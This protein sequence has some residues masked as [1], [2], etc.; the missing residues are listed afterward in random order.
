MNI[1]KW[2]EFSDAVD[3]HNDIEY[4]SYREREDK[5]KKEDDEWWEKYLVKHKAAFERRREVLDALY[6]SYMSPY[7]GFSPSWYIGGVHKT[8]VNF[9][10]WWAGKLELKSRDEVAPKKQ[11]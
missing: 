6:L 8:E 9:W 2:K 5:R 3:V 7:R 11:E 1:E 10:E 4:A